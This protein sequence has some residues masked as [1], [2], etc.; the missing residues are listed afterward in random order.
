MKSHKMVGGYKYGTIVSKEA[1]RTGGKKAVAD[2]YGRKGFSNYK[3]RV[4]QR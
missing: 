2:S 1:L 4:Y 3:T